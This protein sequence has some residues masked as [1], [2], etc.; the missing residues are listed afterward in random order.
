MC[1]ISWSLSRST[2]DAS[3]H[4]SFNF[5]TSGIDASPVI[6]CKPCMAVAGC[7]E[8][9]NQ[10]ESPVAGRGRTRSDNLKLSL[11]Q[12]E[13]NP[14]SVLSRQCAWPCLS[15]FPQSGNVFFA[16]SD[17]WVSNEVQFQQQIV[18]FQ[19]RFSDKI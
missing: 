13:Q 15:P 1:V 10:C 5:G 7:F 17:Y 6:H 3:G 19:F 9:R 16:Q 8:P 4:D 12:L 14:W 11:V 18:L 2:I